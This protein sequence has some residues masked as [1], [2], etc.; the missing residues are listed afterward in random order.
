MVTVDDESVAVL[1]RN[2][3]R[4][5]L[6][7]LRVMADGRFGAT[8]YQS[9][10]PDIFTDIV[11]PL[12]YNDGDHAVGV[13][14]NGLAEIYVDGLLMASDTTDPISSVR[15]S[16]GIQ[17][18][19]VDLYF[20]GDIDEVRVYKRSLDDTEIANLAST[21][22]MSGPPDR[23]PA[24]ALGGDTASPSVLSGFSIATQIPRSDW[25]DAFVASV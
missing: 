6:W 16:T 8:F 2:S 12:A 14:R 15:P 24:I 3:R 7:E 23:A 9:I 10:G 21:T 20:L 18:G 5:G 4:W 22:A 19:L 13:L 11:S 17:I 1:Q 25:V